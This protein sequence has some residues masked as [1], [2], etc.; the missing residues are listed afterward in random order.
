MNRPILGMYTPYH[1]SIGTLRLSER[2]PW[3]CAYRLSIISGNLLKTSYPFFKLAIARVEL[4]IGA[5]SG[6]QT[7]YSD[8]EGHRVITNTL[9]AYIIE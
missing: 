5:G 6:S 3:V 9:P 1:N 7:H 4:E 2:R 8:L